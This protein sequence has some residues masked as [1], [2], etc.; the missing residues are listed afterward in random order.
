MMDI[1]RVHLRPQHDRQQ[2]E[3]MQAALIMA[4]LQ[5]QSLGMLEAVKAAG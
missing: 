2:Q 1:S 5:Q 4:Q 3:R